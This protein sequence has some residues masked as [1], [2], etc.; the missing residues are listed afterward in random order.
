MINEALA[1]NPM[2]EYRTSLRRKQIHQG[3]VTGVEVHEPHGKKMQCALVRLNNG[4]KG[5]IY[6]DQFDRHKFRSLVGFIDHTIDFMVL[7]VQKLGLDPEK[8]QVFDEEKGIV[9]LSRIQALDELQEEFWE[10]AQE[11]HVVTGTVSGWEDERLYLLVKGV[12]CVLAIQ[13]YEYDWTP[14]AR[15]LVPLGTSLTVKIK[16]I[17]REKK[18]VRVSRKEL[19][20]DPWN[21][22]RDNYGVNNYYSGVVTSVVENVGIFVKL[23][24][25]VEALCWFP[26]KS[27]P[28]GTLVGKSVSLRIKNIDQEKRRIRARIIK[29]PHLIY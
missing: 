28:H 29:F 22:V 24:P 13:D 1:A 23:Q 7:D 9:L 11:D 27:P 14:T 26:P 4:L 15:N 2:Q 5:L 16:K 18:Q 12:S 6:E 20:E 19:L 25:G 3:V 8:V 10:T 17:D 21:R